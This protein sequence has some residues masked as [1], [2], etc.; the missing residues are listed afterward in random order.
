MLAQHSQRFAQRGGVVGRV[1][2]GRIEHG[3]VDLRAGER[4]AI[5]L[6][7]HGREVGGVVLRRA[8]PVQR[9]IQNVHRDDVVPAQRE[10]IGEPTAARA[11][12]QNPQ[13]SG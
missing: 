3:Q 13:R 12:I 2:Q 9:V 1:V 10:A 7:Q 4:Q 5:V 6:G 8:E 11:D